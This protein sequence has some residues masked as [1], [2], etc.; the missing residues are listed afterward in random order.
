ML[1]TRR[2]P[3]AVLALLAA[4]AVVASGCLG[5]PEARAS[6]DLANAE[7][8]GRGI[9]ALRVDATLTA[10]AQNWAN[11][12]AS[13]RWVRHSVLSDGAGSDWRRLGENVGRAGSVG[14]M[15][16]LFMN[17]P[18]HRASI[19]NGGFDRIGVGVAE[20]HGQVWVVQVFAG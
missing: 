19:L 6:A 5:T 14:E 9:P 8:T 12:M 15:N 18:S 7:R 11:R 16:A 1:I 20:A 13:E 10:K 17:S 4:V 3:A 2:R